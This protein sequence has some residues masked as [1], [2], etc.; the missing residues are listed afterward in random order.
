MRNGTQPVPSRE[1]MFPPMPT[2]KVRVR[3]TPSPIRGWGRRLAWRTYRTSSTAP[4]TISAGA[5]PSGPT[6]S[7]NTS[8]PLEMATSPSPNRKKPSRSKEP[9][10]AVKF[11]M[12]RAA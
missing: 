11:G 6:R 5:R 7:P 10:A 2:E 3:N 9:R 4:A 1:T 8:S 12:I